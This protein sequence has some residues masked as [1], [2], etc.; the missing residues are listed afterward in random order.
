MDKILFEQQEAELQQYQRLLKEYQGFLNDNEAIDALAQHVFVY[1]DTNQN[2]LLDIDEFSRGINYIT[3]ELGRPP[4]SPERL[5]DDFQRLDLDHNGGIDKYELHQGIIN[6][7]EEAILNLKE[8]IAY[9]QQRV[10]Q[11]V[12]NLLA[13]RIEQNKISQKSSHKKL[14]K[15][16]PYNHH[17]HKHLTQEQY[18]LFKDGSNILPSKHNN[19][20]NHLSFQ[21]TL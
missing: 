12:A 17:N 1:A 5:V 4:Q 20:E 9:E 8:N 13:M 7:V 3:T 14:H 15:K 16:S 6:Y 2:E 19:E 18:L 21:A 10:R 11:Q